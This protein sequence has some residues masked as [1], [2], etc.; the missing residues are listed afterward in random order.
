MAVWIFALILLPAVVSALPA[1]PSAYS[2]PPITINIGYPTGNTG[3][4]GHHYGIVLL[5]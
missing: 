2:Y 5:P 1:L 3:K 4:E